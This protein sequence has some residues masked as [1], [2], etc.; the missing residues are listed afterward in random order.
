MSYLIDTNVVSELRKGARASGGVTRWFAEAADDGM[1]L[2]VLT[3]GE[4]RRGID[5]IQRTD[6]A[7]AVALNRWLLGLVEDFAERIVPVD[8]AV[9][10]EWGRLNVARSLPVIDGLLAATARVHGLTLVT[11]NTK[12]IARTAV[13]CVNPFDQP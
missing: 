6:R 13:H 5:R 10:E 9:A 4:L 12:D 2:S 11:R 3:V 7:S 8:R 1:Y